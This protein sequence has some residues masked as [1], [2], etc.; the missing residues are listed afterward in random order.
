[1]KHTFRGVSLS[2][3]TVAIIGITL[4]G[5]KISFAGSNRPPEGS[6][7]FGTLQKP[8]IE[9]QKEFSGFKTIFADVAEKVTPCVVSV[10]PTKIDTVVFSNNP[11]YQFFG[12]QFSDDDPMNFFFG[13]PQQPRR[14]QRQPQVQKQERRE[15]GLGSGVIVS[16]EGHILTNYHVIAGADEIEV[17]LN[18]GRNYEATIIG[19]DSL[20]DVAVIKIK[21]KIDNLPVVYLGDSDKMRPGD[22]VVAIGNPFSLTATVTV[23]IVSA[24]G[25][26]IGGGIQNAYQNFIQTDAAINPGN[27]GG[28]L[29]NIDGELIGINTMIYSRSGGNMGIGFAIPINMAKRVMEDLIYHGEVT[30]GW[31]GVGIQD[32]DPATRDALDLG[33]RKG[34]LISDVYKGQPADKAGLQRGDI[35]CSIN[36]KETGTASQLRNTVATCKPGNPVPLVV[37]RNGKEINLTMTIA[38]RDEKQIAKLSSGG[39]DNESTSEPAEKSDVKLGINVAN[40]SADIRQKYN[41]KPD[42]KG[43]VVLS[44]DN[45]KGD[46]RS[47]LREGDVITQIKTKGQGFVLVE[48]VK[49]FERITKGLKNGDAVMLLVERNGSSFFA[50]FKLR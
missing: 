20:S 30:R 39:S 33:N 23:G 22:W 2:V 29:V 15:Q 31:I 7:K 35:V 32:I 25:R 8:A 3:V 16:S 47:A 42:T 44:T 4:V 5:C 46:G 13:N 27:S 18:D 49:D 48:S 9:A 38:R 50:S 40:L 21:D 19:S 34:V 28:A 11:F 43:V 36:G 17:K 41:F 10:I 37:L 14:Q 12:D 45:S 24:L 6:V 26:D 1:M